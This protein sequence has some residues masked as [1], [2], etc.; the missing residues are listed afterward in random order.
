MERSVE[1]RAAACP[2]EVQ[3]FLD[4]IGVNVR[5]RDFGLTEADIPKVTS[6]ALTGY[7]FDIKCHPKTVTEEDI[8]DLYKR[9][10]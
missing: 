10:L 7:F 3:K 2:E 1:E 9:C 6:I 4:K 5:F 8:V